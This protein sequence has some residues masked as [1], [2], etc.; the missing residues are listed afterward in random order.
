MTHG[1]YLS[2]LAFNALPRSSVEMVFITVIAEFTV[3][4]NFLTKRATFQ[5]S[6]TNFSLN[7]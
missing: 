3:I 6:H 2:N 1:S 4:F 5:I 7:C